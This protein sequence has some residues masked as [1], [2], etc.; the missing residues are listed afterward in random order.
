MHQTETIFCQECSVLAKCP[1][2]A[3]PIKDLEAHSHQKSTLHYTRG[4]FVFR[5]GEEARY[6]YC[7]ARGSV[8]LFRSSGGREQSFAIVGPGSWM[9]YRDVI[10]QVPYQH[11]AR[12]IGSVHLCRIESS[13][14]LTLIHNFPSFTQ[15]LLADVAN[16]WIESERQSYN[17]GARKTIERLADF[18]L[19]L[20]SDYNHLEEMAQEH[21][22]ITH[23]HTPHGENGNGRRS[24]DGVIEV[25][26]PLTRETVATLIGTTTESVIRTL[27]DFKA[28]GW[29]EFQ[30][31][32]I[33]ILNEAE[34]KRLVNDS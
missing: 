19:G 30:G 6:F 25:E 14:L 13:V 15:T 11:N 2:H 3:V 9:G 24:V 28:R 26:F 27:S 17:L 5:M 29:I 31:S 32:R 34:L 23:S 21:R 10:A 7:V 18:L 22:A 1:F 33:R 8:Q 16:G 4:D 12:A 20:K